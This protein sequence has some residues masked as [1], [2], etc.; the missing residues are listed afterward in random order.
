MTQV[1]P[2]IVNTI[3]RVSILGA[4]FLLGGALWLTT[5][6]F[7]SPYVSRAGVT[8]PQPVAFSHKA[9]VGGLGL[10][11][12]YCHAFVEEAAT[13]GLPPTKTCM[14]CHS[15]ILA[16]SPVLELV[17]ESYD[18]DLPIPWARVHDL[19]DFVRF[20]HSIHVSRGVGCSSC[21]G[22]IDRM[23]LVAQG[24]NLQMDWCLACHRH[25][26][27]ALRPKSE[28]FNL[29]WQPPADQEIRGKELLT[30]HSIRAESLTDCSICHQ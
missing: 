3:S 21:H 4:V 2:P 26:E 8:R 5:A 13:A 14:G 25:P 22:R 15:Q 30:K 6:A 29:A 10:D 18:K 28:V 7:R 11:C 19:P 17:R 23:P 24:S 27:A 20:D 16:K 12:R 1:F 9:H